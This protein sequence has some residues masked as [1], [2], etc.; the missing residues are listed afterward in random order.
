MAPPCPIRDWVPS[1]GLVNRYH[2]SAY[3]FS[4]YHRDKPESLDFHLGPIKVPTP[5]G[6]IRYL[7]ANTSTITLASNTQSGVR[8]AH[9][10]LHDYPINPEIAAQ[11]R[12]RGAVKADCGF[13]PVSPPERAHGSVPLR[14]SSAAA[15][16]LRT[17][18]QSLASNFNGLTP[19]Q[20][21]AIKRLS[22]GEKPSDVQRE[23][24]LPSGYVL[25]WLK[26]PIFI[27]RLREEMA[28][29]LAILDTLLVEG[30]I[31]AAKTLVSALSAQN[32]H[33]KPD[34]KT[35]VEAAESLLNRSG[36]RGPIVE[37]LSASM[38]MK[39]AN[40]EWAKALQDPSVRAWISEK[41]P[42]VLAQILPAASAAHA[43][44][45]IE[46]AIITEVP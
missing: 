24:R 36:K 25:G 11:D 23:L 40:S 30:E 42:Q 39:D 19:I 34:W 35:R 38:E 22:A 13:H 17:E 12:E 21:L 43:E 9:D 33:G 31:E 45:V 4:R 46:D 41:H 2:R 8:A 16:A 20:L 3:T 29:T 18:Q 14:L 10:R 1:R 32:A 27:N 37:K 15:A 7:P 28:N 6:Y 26:L 5:S 44:T